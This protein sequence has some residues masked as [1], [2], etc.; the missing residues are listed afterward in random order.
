MFRI[1]NKKGRR[2]AITSRLLQEVWQLPDP[3]VPM[4]AETSAYFEHYEQLLK[5]PSLVSREETT[6]GRTDDQARKAVA[7]VH[8]VQSAIQRGK[9]L[10][11]IKNAVLDDPPEEL[12]KPITS[13]AVT[14]A[15]D[16]ALRLWLFVPVLLDDDNSTFEDALR[17]SLPRRDP[18]QRA[19][20]SI[21]FNAK[22]LIRRGGFLVRTTSY[23]SQHLEM[24]DLTISVFRH[25]GFLDASRSN[26]S[27]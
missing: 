9:R 6:L 15:I 23:L 26:G 12:L 17:Q 14:N 2:L 8:K 20:L 13:G 22:N 25:A 1:R 24:D 10:G 19:V 3:G 11:E 4:S 21:D 16:F 27:R 18:I 5:D 7:L